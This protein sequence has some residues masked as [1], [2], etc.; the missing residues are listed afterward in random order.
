MVR[1]SAI[2]VAA[3]SGQRMKQ[4]TP[5]QFLKINGKPILQYT[6]QVFET[7]NDIDDI[8]VV[9]PPNLVKKYE[10]VF[11]KEWNIG[12]LYC[13]VQGADQRHLSVWNGLS[14]LPE[15][16][17]IVVIHDGVRPLVTHSIIRNS[18]EKAK[19]TGAAVVGVKSKDTIKKVNHGYITTTIPRSELV[20]VQTPQTFRKK[21]IM[22]ANQTAFKT[23]RFST[24][25]SALVEMAGYPVSVVAGDWMNIK[26]TTPEDLKIAELLLNERSMS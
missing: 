22:A 1:K 5:K 10:S 15:D 6:L 16:T 4:K 8:L 18:I 3:G 12:K 26:I 17:D 7:C 19:E 9:L 2:I 11:K 13:T 20:L 25:D 23:N 21:I 14:V 24:D